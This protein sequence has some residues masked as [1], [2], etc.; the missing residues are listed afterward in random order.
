MQILT[1]IVVHSFV[2]GG[3]CYLI[4]VN[5]AIGQYAAAALG[6]VLGIFGLIIVLASRSKDPTQN[7]PAS[8]AGQLIHYKGLLDKGIIDESEFN[9][10]K[11]NIIAGN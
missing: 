9:R 5:K 2:F 11:S 8:I 3:L 4:G 6:C 1:I 7:D 10:L